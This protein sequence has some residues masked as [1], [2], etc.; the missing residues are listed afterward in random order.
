[1]GAHSFTRVDVVDSIEQISGLRPAFEKVDCL[2]YEGLDKVVL[3]GGRKVCVEIAGEN[4][5]KSDKSG[6]KKKKLTRRDYE[7]NGTCTQ[8]NK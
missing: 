1:M 8:K 2:D 6:K 3:S 4:T 7:K 5:G